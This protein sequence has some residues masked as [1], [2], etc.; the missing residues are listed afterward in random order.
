MTEKVKTAVE[1]AEERAAKGLQER[2]D[3]RVEIDFSDVTVTPQEKIKSHVI[4]QDEATGFDET[5]QSDRFKSDKQSF[6]RIRS[7]RADGP[8][9]VIEVDEGKIDATTQASILG[10]K[11]LTPEEALQRAI[12]LNTMLM[13]E[14]VVLADRKQVENIVEETIVAVLEAQENVMTAQGHGYEDIKR[15]RKARLD[16]I[17]QFEAS[18]KRIRGPQALQ[19]LQGMLLFKKVLKRIAH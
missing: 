15:S 17:E 11:R 7:V 18:A 2:T 10:N 1:V 14:A 16:R 13:H 9:V 4:N 12:A 6:G 5:K 8:N 3:G 19:D